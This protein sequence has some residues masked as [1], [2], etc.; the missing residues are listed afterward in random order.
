MADYEKAKRIKELKAQEAK[1]YTACGNYQERIQEL[2]A[3]NKRL[4]DTIETQGKDCENRHNVICE[5]YENIQEF[6][7]KTTPAIKAYYKSEHPWKLQVRKNK[8]G[9]DK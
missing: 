4:K 7:N 6:H 1:L 3:E 9:K 5:M 2:E 8:P